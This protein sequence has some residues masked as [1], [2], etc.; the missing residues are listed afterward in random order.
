MIYEALFPGVDIKGTMK[1]A[2]RALEARRVSGS[3]LGGSQT[4]RRMTGGLSVQKGNLMGNVAEAVVDTAT[5]GAPVRT[6]FNK[7]KS[8]SGKY[9][10]QM[11]EQEMLNLTRFALSK[12]PDYVERVLAMKDKD[13]FEAI[14][15]LG[16]RF[17]GTAPVTV[18]MLGSS[19]E[20]DP[21]GIV[22]RMF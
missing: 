19:S 15:R 18:G 4:A 21:S 5:L 1:T 9:K 2:K 16:S 13:A 3:I 12:N 22:P 7:M 6:L 17:Y 10:G 8:L 20:V 11:S 14:S